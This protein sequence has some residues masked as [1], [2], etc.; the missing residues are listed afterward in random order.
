ME[1]KL[2]LSLPRDSVSVPVV[3][4]ICAE[5]MN[6]LGVDQECVGDLEVALTEACANVLAHAQTDDDYEVV[7]GIDGVMC[8]IEVIDRGPNGFSGESLG[9]ENAAPAAETGRGIQLMR[10]L[11]DNVRFVSRPERGTVVHLEKKLRWHDGAPLEL[12]N[13]A[14]TTPAQAAAVMDGR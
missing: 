10:T 11:V 2:T 1:I 13:Q 8:V 3:R 9:H 5:S 6:V 12:L 14:E 7:V 4:R